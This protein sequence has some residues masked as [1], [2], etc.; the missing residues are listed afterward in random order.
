MERR[1]IVYIIPLGYNETSS[2]YT[3]VEFSFVVNEKVAFAKD[4]MFQ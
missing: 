2:M 3:F 1:D 4:N